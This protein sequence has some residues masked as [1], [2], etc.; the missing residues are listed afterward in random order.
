MATYV[1]I[2]IT[3]VANTNS[4]PSYGSGLQFGLDVALALP[5]PSG[6]PGTAH[7]CKGCF[8]STSEPIS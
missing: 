5:C 4:S 2:G 7:I 8:T 3:P 1:L 6:G